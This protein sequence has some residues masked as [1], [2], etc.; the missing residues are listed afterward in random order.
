VS[1]ASQRLFIVVVFINYRISPE[2]FGYTL[3]C[4]PKRRRSF[5]IN[6]SFLSTQ[7]LSEFFFLCCVFS[8]VE[9]IEYNLIKGRKHTVLLT[10]YQNHIINF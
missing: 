7:S 6:A 1:V 10:A 9:A 2:M 5:E 4:E 8:H 3:V